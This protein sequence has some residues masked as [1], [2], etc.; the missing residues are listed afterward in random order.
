MIKHDWEIFCKNHS[1]NE[2]VPRIQKMLPKI[3]MATS[4]L[5]D[6]TKLKKLL[7]SKG[8]NIDELVTYHDPCHARKVQGIYQEPRELLAQ[9]YSM[10]EMSDP[11]RCCGFGGVTMQT[12]KFHLAQKAGEPKSAMIKETKATIVSAECSACRVQLSEALNHNGVKTL[13]KNPIELIAKAL[14]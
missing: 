8:K 14:T 4:W 9:N 2:L 11:N 3:H 7:A 5:H 12:E 10:V 1:M 13:F 6:N